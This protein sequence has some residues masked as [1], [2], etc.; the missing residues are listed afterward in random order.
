MPGLLGY[1]IWITG[2]VLQAYVVVRAIKRKELLL[3]PA[4]NFYMLSACLI[5]VVQMS[6]Y[7]LYGFGSSQYFYSY[8]WGDSLLIVA[9]YFAVKGLY[10]HVFRDLAARAMIPGAFVILLVA[11]VLY[12]CVAAYYH[13]AGVSTQFNAK[14]A[15]KFFSGLSQN[16]YFVGVVLTYLLWVAMLRLRETRL[17]LVQLVLALGMYFSACAAL[18]ALKNLFPDLMII[19][20]LTPVVNLCLPAAWAYTFTQIPEEARLATDRLA[21]RSR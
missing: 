13:N 8:Y 1:L 3:Y 2:P 14:Q 17:R 16:L 21:L 15:T 19:K 6:V 9:L 18:F 12:S 20:S 5:T 4:V 11:T 7:Q 10:K